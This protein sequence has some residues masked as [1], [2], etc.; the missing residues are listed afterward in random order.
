VGIEFLR[1]GNILCAGNVV[2]APANNLALVPAVPNSIIR[3]F[4]INLLAT[5][6]ALGSVQFKSGSGGP[7]LGAPF[8]FPANSSATPNAFFPI[9]ESGYFETGVGAAL[10]FDLFLAGVAVTVFYKVYSP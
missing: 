9:T 10:V 6:A 7:N 4:G 3:V 8:G 2:G 1:G 5:G